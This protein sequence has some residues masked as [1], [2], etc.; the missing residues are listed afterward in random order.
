ML[1]LKVPT[2][3]HF[4]YGRTQDT[5]GSKPRLLSLSRCGQFRRFR[6]AL[7]LSSGVSLHRKL[8]VRHRLI[9]TLSVRM[10]SVRASRTL[11]DR[12][13]DNILRCP[14]SFFD[15][16]PLGRIVNR[17]SKGTPC[18]RETVEGGA[19][20]FFSFFSLPRVCGVYWWHTPCFHK[21]YRKH[22]GSAFGAPY[23]CKCCLRENSV[24]DFL[25]P[26]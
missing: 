26:R 22:R 1:S 23:I 11:H 15:T 2:A 8:T 12:L 16:T 21:H 7:S 19:S 14:M 13:V 24:P 3:I 5:P 18:V 4:N 6:R 9:A 20:L 25:P 17:F 10:R